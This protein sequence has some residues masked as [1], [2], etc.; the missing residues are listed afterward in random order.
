MGT[1][2]GG[3]CEW[4]LRFNCPKH[5]PGAAQD[6]LESV[7]LCV[8]SRSHFVQLFSGPFLDDFCEEFICFFTKKSLKKWDPGRDT[9]PNV[10]R[11]R[12]GH[13]A[14]VVALSSNGD[15]GATL[16][17][18]SIW[19]RHSW[20]L[21]PVAPPAPA[22]SILV[23]NREKVSQNRKISIVLSSSENSSFL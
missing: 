15:C 10:T 4:Y 14:E 7:C 6:R 11:F 17:P 22:G 23:Q 19:W 20:R 18:R 2:F 5:V 21:A 9:T 8:C 3:F 16:P 12:T 13:L 1:R